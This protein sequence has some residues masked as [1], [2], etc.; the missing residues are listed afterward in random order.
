MSEPAKKPDRTPEGYSPK[1]KP[2]ILKLA[3]GQPGPQSQ[4]LAEN[5]LRGIPRMRYGVTSAVCYIGCVKQ[6]LAYL[7]DPIEDEELFALSGAGLCFPWQAGSCCDE[8]SV[9]PEIPRRTFAALGYGSEYYYEQDIS[10]ETR[11]YTKDFYAERIKASI[12]AGR[13]VLGFGLTAQ[14]FTCLITGYY[15]GGEGLYLRAFWSPQ[16]KPEGY[17]G[18]ET[19]YSVDDWYDKCHG[20][21]VVG[22]KTGGRLV[23][24]RAYA[25]IKD[26]AALFSRMTS[27]TAQ[28]QAIH[29]GFSAFDAMAAWLRDDSR[30]G[31]PHAV[32]VFLKP[33][34]VLLLQYYRNH[35]R[36]YL[37]KLAAQCP[38]LVHPGICPAIERMSGLIQG[39]QRSDWD[40]RKIDRRIT[41]FSKLRRR[42]LREKVATYVERLKAID[43][44]IF[45][46]LSASP[47]SYS[48]KAKPMLLNLA[49]ALQ[50]TGAPPSDAIADPFAGGEPPRA[51][52]RIL[53]YR[54]IQPWENYF[55]ASALCSMGRALGSDIDSLHFYSA[56]TGDMFTPLY[57]TQR[58]SC[59]SGVTNSFFAPQVIKKAYAAMGRGCVY[60][61]TEY[62]KHNFR[63]VMNAIKASVDR[64]IPVLA[65]GMGNVAIDDGGHCDPLPEGCL[66]GGYGGDTLYVNLYPGPERV[67]VGDDGY[68]AI[69]NGLDTTYGLF[70]VGEP[71]EKT[72]MREVY[73]DA[74]ASIPS[75]LTLPPAD[76]LLFGQSAFE[77]WADTLL[78]ES[79]FAGKTDEE[80][81][82]LGITWDIHCAPYC[83][84]CTSD[85]LRF[86]KKAAKEY[87]IA[88]AKRILPLYKKFFK[89]KQ[90]IWKLQ[91]GFFPPVKK[92]RQR[93]F[94]EKIARHLREMGML[95]GEI[96]KTAG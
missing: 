95:C 7:Q 94:R 8:I 30:W 82:G 37:E 55:L 16:G 52:N 73:R 21:V 24:E 60:L 35:L 12:D 76:D 45:D 48:P 47:E 39:A 3:A 79:N 86:V 65:W 13:P 51:S 1:R 42:E 22:E 23:G 50:Q 28:G 49:Q 80:I 17:D 40:L 64:G 84:V 32:S 26:T 38:G 18:E 88:A 66:I 63:A 34:G 4:G 36:L 78:D 5:V 83:T 61:S 77:I 33:C 15:D 58:K 67:E 92:F 9:V 62:I 11:Q 91:K 89:H 75:L 71:I 27:V 10:G 19:Y 20:I 68:T 59:D 85:A 25:H 93:K 54:K 31:D 43:R 2:E 41:D 69:T 6:L 29:T 56:I 87:K 96:A 53:N 44:E 46:C 74:I 81:S 57:S 70:F 14:V 72:P 90:R